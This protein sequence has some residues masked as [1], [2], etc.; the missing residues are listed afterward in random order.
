MLCARL[1]VIVQKH[2]ELHDMKNSENIPYEM[3]HSTFKLPWTQYI[4]QFIWVIKTQLHYQF[5]VKTTFVCLF[6]FIEA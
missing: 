2:S 6:F 5:A 3:I 1:H 4:S